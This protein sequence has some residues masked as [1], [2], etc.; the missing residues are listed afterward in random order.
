MNIFSG[1]RRVA[2]II[3]AIWVTG[4]LV[5]NI[6]TTPSISL[7]YEVPYF[8]AT[9]IHQKERIYR[10][11]EAFESGYKEVGGIEEAVTVSMYFLAS[12]ASDGRMLIPYQWNNGRIL[13]NS[14]YDS[15]VKA[16]TEKV[17]SD[18][19][20][21][22]PG[23]EEAHQQH[24]QKIWQGFVDAATYAISGLVIWWLSVAVIGWIVRGFLGIPFGKDSKPVSQPI[25]SKNEDQ[26]P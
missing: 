4:A 3:A 19:N 18:F 9:P 22:A 7:Q 2:V 26:N 12:S 13:M 21:D 20:V 14:R 10:S 16:Y 24:K 11:E 23:A 1:S 17:V 15:D 8:G 25:I 5:V 6:D